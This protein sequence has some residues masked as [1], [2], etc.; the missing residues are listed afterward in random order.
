MTFFF[1]YHFCGSNYLDISEYDMLFNAIC[2]AIHCSLCQ[3]H[4]SL[5]PLS[6]LWSQ[7]RSSIL[8][9]FPSSCL[10]PALVR[11]IPLLFFANNDFFFF[12]WSL[13]SCLIQSHYLPIQAGILVI[14]LFPPS[15]FLLFTFYNWSGSINSAFS[16]H[17]EFCKLLP[18][19]I[20]SQP[21][22]SL[23]GSIFTWYRPSPSSDRV[24][25][26]INFFYLILF[27]FN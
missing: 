12:F 16:R 11:I 19:T 24:F 27:K 23:H 25:L 26:S 15:K 21:L 4:P 3:Q 2:V 5:Q 18:T 14:L 20:I 6:S 7:L 10:P 9:S 13:T 1:N 8:W 17:S 22:S